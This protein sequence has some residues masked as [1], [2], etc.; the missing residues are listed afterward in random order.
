G[1]RFEHSYYDHILIE[2]APGTIVGATDPGGGAVTVGGEAGAGKV[3]LNGMV[4]GLATGDVEVA[5]EGGERDLLLLSVKWLA[6]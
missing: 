1:D 5:P 4:T 6:Q 2:A 3:V